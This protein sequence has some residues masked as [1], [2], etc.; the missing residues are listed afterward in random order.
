MPLASMSKV[1]SI[2]GSPRGDGRDPGQLEHAELLVVRRDLTLA[3]E[4]LDLH[5]RLVVLGRGEDLRPLGRDR[6]VPLDE[7]GEDAALGLDAQRQRGHVEQQ[8]VLDL[9]LEHAGLQ[10]GADRDDLVRVD[11]LVRLLAAGQRLDQ[12][13]HR[14]HPGGPADQH[15]VVQVV[16][17]D[18]GVLDHLLERAL[19]PV[20]QVGGHP[21]ELRAGQLGVQVQR[22]V[23][24]VGDVGQ[25]DLRLHRLGQLDLGLL[26]GLTQPLQR[27]LVLGQVDAV[28]VLEVLD[29]PVDD[30]LV[31][32]VAAEVVVAV[33]RLDLDDALADL[34]Q[35]HVEGPAAQVE[36]ED[37]G[38]AL[39]LQVVGQRGR[40]GLVDD[41]EHVQ[42]RDL[43]GLG[44]GLTL[45]VVEVRRD[46]DHRVGDLLTQVGFRVP[47]ELL[48]H[49][50][51]DLLGTELLAVD[52]DRPVGPH[53]ALDRTDGPVHVGD[54]LPLGDLA[55]QYLRV[56]GEGHDRGSRP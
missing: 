45:R 18:P 31:P 10:A 7:L 48:Q 49:E 42:P 25:V 5:R 14:G 24:G 38:L 28:P 50:R 4:D 30:P 16:E 11:A 54:G 6:G 36:D 23:G 51:A 52:V 29:Q 8:D 47:L 9:A 35:G 39:L 37:G 17:L 55:D 12:V 44:G 3:L 56:L 40:G 19:A 20:E 46:G 41:P 34:K 26:R 43:P 15:H 53:V 1:T 22:A 21:L 32:V 27:H 33:G 13:D 2:C